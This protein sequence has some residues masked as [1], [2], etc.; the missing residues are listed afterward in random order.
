[1]LSPSPES[2]YAFA[3][4]IGIALNELDPAAVPAD[5]RSAEAQGFDL[6]ASGEHLFFHGPI[7]NAFVTL[8]TAAAVTDTSP[9]WRSCRYIPPLWPPSWPQPSIACS[10]VDS[11]WDGVA[12]EFPPEFAAAGLG[13]DRS[14]CAKPVAPNRINRTPRARPSCVARKLRFASAGEPCGAAT[15]VCLVTWVRGTYD[16]ER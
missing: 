3:I 10:V 7:P 11:N 2:S 9:R 16:N 12:G 8:V 4:R 6:V 13:N 15:P 1:M 5:V 14:H